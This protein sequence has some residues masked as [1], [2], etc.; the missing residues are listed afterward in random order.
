M[1][2]G[3][4]NSLSL[5]GVRLL[6]LFVTYETFWQIWM[7]FYLKATDRGESGFAAWCG[8]CEHLVFVLKNCY[9]MLNN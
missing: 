7:N 2:Q 9:L 1:P 8:I 6:D 3:D 4:G 5:T